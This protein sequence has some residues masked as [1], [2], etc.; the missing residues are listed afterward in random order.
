[1]GHNSIH[2]SKI[3]QNLA[4]RCCVFCRH[5]ANYTHN[6]KSSLLSTLPTANNF[7]NQRF[8]YL[9]IC[10]TYKYVFDMHFF[11]A[12]KVRHFRFFFYLIFCGQT[13]LTTGSLWLDRLSLRK[14][15]C[16][17]HVLLCF[18]VFRQLFPSF[19]KLNFMSL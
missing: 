19:P 15:V 10:N 2:R 7:R 12:H 6:A 11:V 14:S 5:A 16:K 9:S 17:N 13:P 18:N 1:M 4:K 8:H 3:R